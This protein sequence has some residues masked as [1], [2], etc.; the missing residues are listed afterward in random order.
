MFSQNF[1]LH[2][3]LAQTFKNLPLGF[4][5]SYRIIKE[6]HSSIKRILIFINSSILIKEN[7]S[8]L[9]QISKNGGFD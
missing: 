3:F 9:M 6:F 2:W 8:V 4:L 7:Y 5:I 1:N